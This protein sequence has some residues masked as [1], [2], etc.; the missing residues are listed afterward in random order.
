MTFPDRV[1]RWAIGDI[2]E[3][4]GRVT[5]TVT[6][7]WAYEDGELVERVFYTCPWCGNRVPEWEWNREYRSCE[8]CAEEK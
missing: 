3:G 8:E 6:A 2:A 5:L 1:A 4:G 7:A